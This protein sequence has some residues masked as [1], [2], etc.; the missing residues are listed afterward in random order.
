[1]WTK[2]GSL[3]DVDFQYES[4]VKTWPIDP[5]DLRNVQLEVSK[6]HHTDNW[7]VAAKRSQRR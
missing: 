4:T 1:M 3:L 7:L 6:N 2:R 5:L